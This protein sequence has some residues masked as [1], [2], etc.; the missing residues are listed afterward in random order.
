MGFKLKTRTM[1]PADV[2]VQSPLLLSK[3][4]IRYDFS[5]NVDALFATPTITRPNTVGVVDGSSANAGSVGEY[6]ESNITNGASVAAGTT[7]NAKTMTSLTL[8]PGDW[9]VAGVISWIPA[10]TT[11]LTAHYASISLT[12]NVVD[13]TFG[14]INVGTL[15]SAIT[16]AGNTTN[17]N[18]VMPCRFNV[19][20]NTIIYLVGQAIYGVST[21]G[22]YGNLRARRIR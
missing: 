6:I 21:L 11:T 1:F 13:F 14:R 12:T 4:G 22:M 9:D 20:A 3:S 16:G 17:S 19:S 5:I 2:T 18:V 8:T 10:A 7:G 15:P